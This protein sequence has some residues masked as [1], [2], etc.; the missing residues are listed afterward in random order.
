MFITHYEIQNALHD[1]VDMNLHEMIDGY[2]PLTTAFYLDRLDAVSRA[3]DMTDNVNV[4]QA[5]A[6]A[7][8]AESNTYVRQQLADAGFFEEGLSQLLGFAAKD[9]VLSARLVPVFGEAV[10]QAASLD[11]SELLVDLLMEQLERTRDSWGFA[12]IGIDE[13]GYEISL[14]EETEI[15]A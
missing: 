8:V 2:E 11:L 5:A 1:I 9:D 13:D 14:A 6:V 7:I 4:H 15:C 12:V 10:E 3:V